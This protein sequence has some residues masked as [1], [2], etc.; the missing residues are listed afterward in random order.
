[1]SK[2]KILAMVV[3][4]AGAALARGELSPFAPA[5]II[6]ASEKSASGEA[7]QR[8]P[9][10]RARPPRARRTERPIPGLVTYS[11]GKT[12]G[13]ERAHLYR[14]MG[15]GGAVMDFT[16]YGARPVRAYLPNA[17]GALEDVLAGTRR[18]VIDCEKSGELAKVWKMTPIRR[19]RATGLVFELAEGV[20]T[21]RVV[22]LL[23]AANVLSVETTLEGSETNAAAFA[24]SIDFRP[25]A[26]GR[27]IEVVA[28][29]AAASRRIAATTNVVSVALRPTTNATQ[30][31]AFRFK[32]E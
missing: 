26:A 28:P 16:D 13:G 27:A 17:T 31:I 3:A 32:G 30:R 20:A 1:M 18:S 5:Q 23:D 14:I 9:Q 24:K 22:Y 8:P 29:D 25:L 12:A 21:N 11:F 10:K 7:A 6:P 4:A 19:P 15:Q 2:A